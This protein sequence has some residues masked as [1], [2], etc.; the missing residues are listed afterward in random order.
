[1]TFS[2]K[3]I[4]LIPNVSLLSRKLL[5]KA[6]Q[7]DVFVLMYDIFPFRV[8]LSLKEETAG[9]DGRAVPMSSYK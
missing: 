9:V 3:S 2:T 8:K 1:M 5:N 4:C 7:K 6:V